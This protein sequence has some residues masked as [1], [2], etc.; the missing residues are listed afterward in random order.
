MIIEEGRLIRE[1][2]GA[3]EMESYVAKLVSYEALD[4]MVDL[5]QRVYNAL[6]NKEVLFVDSYEDM[7]QDLD[8]GAKVIGIYGEENQMIAY[9]YV[10]FPGLQERNLGRDVGLSEH[11]LEKLC[12]LETTVVD[13][14]YRGNN[15]QYMTLSLMKPIVAAEGYKHMAC[16]IS[17]YNYFSVNNIMRHGLKIKDLKKKYGTLPDNS[18]GIWRYIL[19]ERI[20]REEDFVVDKMVNVPM[21][22]IQKQKELLEAGFV[23]H[24]LHRDQSLDYVQY[25]SLQENSR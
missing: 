8:E 19:H 2:H 3:Q 4:H 22:M 18:D 7:K 9:R 11:E 6:P 14:P 15:L 25:S 16:T 24:R 20:D 1:R 10:S 23:G 13:P 5:I 21:T 17:P 12:Q